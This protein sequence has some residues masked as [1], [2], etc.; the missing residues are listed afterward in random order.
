MKLTIRPAIIA[1]VCFCAAPTAANTTPQEITQLEESLPICA[2]SCIIQ[3]AT[4]HN[5]TLSD[6]RCSC[7]H[8]SVNVRNVLPCLV[9]A[10]CNLT[11]LISTFF[12]LFW[13]NLR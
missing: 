12:V 9:R 6:F 8:I 7:N 11:E 10:G 13:R 5:C 4:A 3:G 1:L 2:V